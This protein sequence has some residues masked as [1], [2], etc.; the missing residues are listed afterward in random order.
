M[1]KNMIIIIAVAAIVVI[2]GGAAGAVVLMN[3]DS[4]DA[5]EQYT[6]TYVTNGG[7]EIEV[8]S[9]TANT[10]TFDLYAIWQENCNPLGP[11]GGRILYFYFIP[12]TGP[13][14]GVPRVRIM[15]IIS[16]LSF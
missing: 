11:L 12:R 2:A 1:E 6:L 15:S 5:E 16:E 14:L 8:K 3:D 4:S 10:D 13:T 7:A 9:F